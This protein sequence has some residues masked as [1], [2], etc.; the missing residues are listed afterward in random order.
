LAAALA[1]G[2]TPAPELVAAAEVEGALNP[3]VAAAC[4]AAIGVGVALLIALA[5]YFQIARMTPLDLSPDALALRATQILSSAGF[6]EPAGDT[7]DGLEV[8][9]NYLPYVAR[10]ADGVAIHERLPTERPGA[11]YYWYRQVPSQLKPLAGASHPSADNPPLLTPGSADVLLDSRGNLRGLLIVPPREWLAGPPREVDWQPLF[12]A[13]GLDLA[14]FE[15]TTANWDR[16]VQADTKLAWRGVHPDS[17]GTEVTVEAG[18]V[19]GHAVH[20]LV[21]APWV[22]DAR[23]NQGAVGSRAGGVILSIWFAASLVAAVLIARRNLRLGRGDRRASWRLAVV[24]TALLFVWWLT[25]TH[26]LSGA[27][28]LNLFIDG[29]ANALF[30][31]GVV[32]LVYMA[33]EPSYR[34]LWPGQLVAWVRLVGGRFRDPL[35]GRDVLLGVLWGVAYTAIFPMLALGS[36]RAGIPLSPP[37]PAWGGGPIGATPVDGAGPMLS[38]LSLLVATQLLDNLIFFVSLVALR[39][40]L[41]NTMAAFA[42]ILVGVVLGFPSATANPVVAAIITVLLAGVNFLLLFRFGV[43]FFVLADVV[44]TALLRFPLTADIGSWYFGNTVFVV[45][46]VGGL[47]AYGFHTSLAGKSVFGDEEAAAAAPA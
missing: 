39:L 42:V 29:S 24:M 33:I 28:E 15:A 4:L 19:G 3:R 11:I 10:R 38:A 26:H 17:G 16:S 32:W 20:F 7:M 40:A 13:A 41:R 5:P 44:S 36:A 1:A 21:V 43:L 31:G 30:W 2:E 25:G 14:G 47:A 45:L 18:A 46:V 8:S 37:L 9:G 12:A 34:R 23:Q 27:G 6:E 35:V 22:E